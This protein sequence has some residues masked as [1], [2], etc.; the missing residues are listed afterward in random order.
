ML[1]SQS[2]RRVIVP[3]ALADRTGL[4]MVC[5]VIAIISSYKLLDV[6]DLKPG[7]IAPFNATAPKT[8]FVIDT[9]ALQQQR[10]DLIPRT[11][12]QVIDKGESQ[13]IQE[14]LIKQLGYLEKVSSGTKGS[15]SFRIGP[16]NL[17]PKE[18]E[19]L[20]NQTT[21][22]R[23]QW[24]GEIILLSQKMLSQGLIKTLAH[25]Q[26][27]E[28]AKFQL[29]AQAESNNPSIN[30]GS[31]LIANTLFGKTNL[32]HDAARS[33]QLLEELITKQGIPEIEVKKGD[34]ITKKGERIT[35]KGY[36]VL[37]HFGLIRRSARPLEWFGKF[38]EALA[39]CLVL[40]M[41]MRRDKPSLKPKNGL[42]P[43]GLLLIVQASKDWFGAAI[44]PLQ[45]L[46]PPTLLLSQG[47]ST[48][49]ALGWMAIASL[50]WPVPV[51]GIGEGR[52]IIA[53]LTS[54]LVAI[55]GGRMRSRA[56]LLQVVVFVP[57]SAYLSQWVLLRSQLFSSGG[58]WR[59]L[60]P[61]SETLL[62]EAL[63]L[64][65]ILMFTIL[66]IPIIE[67]T[68][69][70]LTRARLMEISDQEKPLLRRL[71]KEAPGTFE[72][73]L[74]ICGL[75]EEGARSIGADVDLIRSGALYHD[76]GKLHAPEWFIENQENGVNPH[77]TLDDPLKS[78]DILQAHVDE[79][80]KL[81]RRYR[82]PTPIAD[83]IPEHQGTLKMGYFLHKAKE[84]NPSVEEKRFRYKGP[85]PRSK[86][87]AIL[88]MADGCEAAL[89]ALG[90]Q[91]TDIDAESTI[92]KIIRSR[93]LDGQLLK[94]SISNSEIE[95][96]IRA[97]ISVWRRMRHRRIKYPISSFKASYPA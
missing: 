69:G 79:G 43:L 24:E 47:I 50:L 39:S 32:Q 78:A 92:R 71:S 45:I 38:S 75:A 15:N 34:L 9:A 3:W 42:L 93:K 94:S 81:A 49:T 65:A 52:L 21:K 41:I 54:T 1:N 68:F 35:A 22:S 17:T 8:A 72:H 84:K 60:S 27:L 74:M 66:L 86:E 82:L 46:V 61:N 76:V 59:K 97:F 83:F 57:F 70:L 2:P 13:K 73:T 7:D 44:S 56:Q 88:M 33:Q 58:V 89:R 28:S 29:S 51:S 10:K 40:L 85:V 67:N 30:L 48:T 6:P 96:V 25:D 11:S 53:V 19:W 26:I 36:V 77:E 20:A 63:V 5:L 91:S 31:K 16:V 37:D 64:G 4:L 18:R 55:L 90:P 87:T 23:K 80:L 62:T 12:V 14:E 95:L